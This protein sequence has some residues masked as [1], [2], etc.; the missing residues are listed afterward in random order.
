MEFRAGMILG[1][2][3]AS[4]EMLRYLVDSL[5]VM[6]TPKWVGTRGQPIAIADVLRCLVAAITRPKVDPGVYELGGPDV[7]T[8][9]ELMNAYAQ[10]AGLPKRRLIPVPVLTPGLSAHWV[11]LV[12]PVPASLATE[13]VESLVNEVVVTGER[14]ARDFGVEPMPLHEALER[15]L[16]A[17]RDGRVPSHFSDAD[18]LAFRPAATDPEWAGGPVLRDERIRELDLEPDDVFAAVKRIG[19]SRGWYG[20]G[21]LWRVRGWLDLVA[22]GPGLRRGR[23]DPDDLRPGEPLDFWRV[24]EVR[25]G[26][27]RLRAE[28]LLPGSAWLTYEV[29]G[30]GTGS[31]ITQ[32]AE[33]HPSGLSGR[34]YWYAVAPFHRFVFPGLLRGIER[35]ARHLAHAR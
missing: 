11:G 15:A 34:V 26:R 29:T 21:W 8:Y 7:V 23:R 19:G 16:A 14:T 6:V 35:D 27:L 13:L 22:G 33:F 18:L 28:M 30:A 24:E 10:A 1:S 9:A 3:S 25:P 4:F 5:P 2:G 32:V 17:Q 20:G 31:R 12:T